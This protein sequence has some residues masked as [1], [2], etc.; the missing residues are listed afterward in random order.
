[1]VICLVNFGQKNPQH[2][3]RF[4]S[5]KVHAPTF[6]GPQGKS[7]ISGWC[8]G[9]SKKMTSYRFRTAHAE[10][11]M[12]ASAIIMVNNG[13]NG[14]LHNRFMKQIRRFLKMLLNVNRSSLG[15]ILQIF[16]RLVPRV[17]DGYIQLNQA[18]KMSSSGCTMSLGILSQH[19]PQP[20]DQHSDRCPTFE[21]LAAPLLQA[22]KPRGSLM[23]SPSGS[24]NGW[25]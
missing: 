20:K 18:A 7:S 9:S 2:R 24:S 11:F 3:H 17:H 19:F 12:I 22:S 14:V 25:L 21:H 4:D 1:M 23:R 15:T 5:C 6:S 8:H 16:S 10:H 13:D